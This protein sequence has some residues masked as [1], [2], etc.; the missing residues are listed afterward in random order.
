[1]TAEMLEIDRHRRFTQDPRAMR[2]RWRKVERSKATREQGRRRDYDISPSWR[3][4]WSSRTDYGRS[5]DAHIIVYSHAF[6][7]CLIAIHCTAPK[8]RL[9]RPHEALVVPWPGV[10]LNVLH[11]SVGGEDECKCTEE[12]NLPIVSHES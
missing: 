11:Q 6:T 1:M 8:Y 10:I 9:P 7:Q 2:R 4:G 3:V 5:R 12:T